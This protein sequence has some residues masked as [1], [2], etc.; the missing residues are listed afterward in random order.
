MRCIGEKKKGK[1]KKKKKKIHKQAIVHHRGAWLRNHSEKNQELNSDQSEY[2]VSE[3]GINL[4]SRVA[5][6]VHKEQSTA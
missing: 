5:K 1:N 4:L 3:R 2:T 6:H